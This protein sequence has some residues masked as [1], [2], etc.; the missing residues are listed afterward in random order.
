LRRSCGRKGLTKLS[1][2]H[3]L[4]E[5]ER[6]DVVW[7]TVLVQVQGAAWGADLPAGGVLRGCSCARAVLS[8]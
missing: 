8:P 1:L 3:G 7:V 2:Y 4:G 5:L 6:K